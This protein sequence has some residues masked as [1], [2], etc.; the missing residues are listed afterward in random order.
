MAASNYTVF[1][2]KHVSSIQFG[3]TAWTTAN[4]TATATALD[5]S[6]AT[7]NAA[8]IWK[9]VAARDT[10]SPVKAE[11][12]A[13]SITFSGGERSTD[14]ENLLG[15]DTGGTQNQEMTINPAALR[16]CTLE[17]VYRN[18]VPLSIFNDT[19]RAV[20][21]TLDNSESTGTGVLNVACNNVT[22]LNVGELTINADGLVTQQVKFSFKG[23]TT[24][25][26]S[27][28]QSAP[29]ETWYKIYG[30]DYAEE[31]RLT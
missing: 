5:T 27:V 9:A 1:R 3:S 21:M 19:T 25:A 16:E 14:V 2:P 20:L 7:N 10:N 4:W 15:S 24:T 11:A 31:I 13:R 22:V 23:G 26:V 12:F 18:N 28:T 29:S 8:P 17:V 6:F 30:G